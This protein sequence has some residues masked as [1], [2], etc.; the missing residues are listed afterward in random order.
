[1]ALLENL[2]KTKYPIPSQIYICTQ[3]KTF[4]YCFKGVTDALK[5]IHRYQGTWPNQVHSNNTAFGKIKLHCFGPN[6]ISRIKIIFLF[7]CS[8]CILRDQLLRHIPFVH[9]S[10]T[11]YSVEPKLFFIMAGDLWVLIFTYEKSY[12]SG[13]IILVNQ[14]KFIYFLEEYICKWYI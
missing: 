9:Q 8:L 5:L 14:I 1:M 4:E 13:K 11:N 10:L 7:K 2:M 3:I 6:L 12:I